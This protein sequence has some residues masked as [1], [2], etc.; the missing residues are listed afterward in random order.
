MFLGIYGVDE[1]RTTVFFTIADQTVRTEREILTYN[2]STFVADVGGYLGL[3][4]GLSLFDVYALAVNG[5]G[6]FINIFG[7]NH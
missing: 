4:L 6:K 7:A 3:L 5:I 1:N 2:F